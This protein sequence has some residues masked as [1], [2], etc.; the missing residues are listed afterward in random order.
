V[1]DLK[2]MGEAICA[3]LASLKRRNKR[4]IIEPGR[5]IAAN[6]AVLL[7]RLEYMKQSWENRIAVA[8]AGMNCLLRPT[9]YAAHHM[10]WPASFS[11]FSG[12]WTELHQGNQALAAVR[13]ETVD[14]VGPICE[15]GD[16]FAL[17]YTCRPSKKAT[18]W[19]YFHAVPTA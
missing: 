13:Q 9:L 14:V 7:T 4:F 3:R 17:Q 5:S 8:D 11:T 15:T 2:G 12:H 6:S 16:Y 19:R 18:C 1:P 10:I